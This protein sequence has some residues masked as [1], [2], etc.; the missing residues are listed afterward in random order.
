M[1]T[2]KWLTAIGSA[3]Q[4]LFWAIGYFF[5]F[6]LVTIFSFG[7]LVPGAFDEIGQ[8]GQKSWHLLYRRHGKFHLVAEVVGV[9][10][11]TF[12]TLLNWWWYLSSLG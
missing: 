4:T 8:Y 9:V 11:W 6:T 2:D 10:G 12:L 1:V 7:L 3:T 5:G